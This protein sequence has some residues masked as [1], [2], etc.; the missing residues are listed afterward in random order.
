MARK[1]WSQL[2]PNVRKRY[3]SHG[4]GP[5]EHAR[6]VSLTAARGHAKT[7][8]R[9]E[10]AARNPSKY[11]DYIANRSRLAAQVFAKKQRL[12]GDSHK[13]NASRARAAIGR[14]PATKRAPSIAHMNMF[15]AMNESDIL[16]IDWQDDDWAFIFYH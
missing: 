16:D 2:S 4:I 11:P 7:P 13:W 5:R 8:E 14:N 9:P 3:Q 12:F 1:S 10:R 6:G 15:L